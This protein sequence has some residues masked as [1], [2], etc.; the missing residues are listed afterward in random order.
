MKLKSINLKNYRS[1]EDIIF[2]IKENNDKSFTYGLIGVNEA[3]KSS[4][5]KGIALIDNLAI[6]KITQKDFIIKVIP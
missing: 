4:V 6:I 1:V 3:G 2:H 5:L